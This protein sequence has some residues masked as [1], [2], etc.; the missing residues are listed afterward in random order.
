MILTLFTKPF[1]RAL[2]STVLLGIFTP[3]TA[4]EVSAISA[5][6]GPTPGDLFQGAVIDAGP[7]TPA[8]QSG[9][10]LRDAFGGRFSTTEPGR[11]VLADNLG[12]AVQKIYFHTAAPV[13]LSS[14]KLYLGDNGVDRGASHVEVA[15]TNA[16]FSSN[17]VFSTVDLASPY[18]SAVGENNI[19]HILISDSFAPVTGQYFVLHL[20][21][22]NPNVGVR[23]I[24]FDGV[25]PSGILA[26]T[27]VDFSTVGFTSALTAQTPINGFTYG[28]YTNSNMTT[29]TFSTDN[30]SVS[31]VEWR[32]TEASFTPIHRAIEMHP[33]GNTLRS[34]VRRYTVGSGG[35]PAFTGTVRIVGR[36][37]FRQS[38][39][40]SRFVTVDGTNRR[41]EN[42]T[43]GDTA[44]DFTA[45]VTPASTIDFG[46]AVGNGSDASFDMTGLIAWIVSEDAPVPTRL[47]ANAYNSPAND[48]DACFALATDLVIGATDETSFDTAPSAA[49]FPYAFAGLL[50]LEN[51]GSGKAT[52]FDSVRIDMT[53]S[54]DFSETPRLYLLRHNSDPNTSN[55]A[56]DDAT[57][58]CPS[59]RRGL[60]R[61]ARASLLTRSTSAR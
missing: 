24:E 5:D 11:A 32:S 36:F 59:C 27:H 6:P 46:V 16:T 18:P 49:A 14:F 43:T 53:T 1:F 34:A 40:T 52:R 47:L 28:Y 26:A 2:C 31:G 45:N 33:S 25:A 29:G 50:Y 13:T 57:R 55:P 41:E 35:E 48:R 10:D 61:I 38:G 21:P 8:H 37:F 15:V 9:H 12:S 23:V 17:T 3:A 60:R 20:T 42:N 7:S 56:A 4:A 44:F 58:A 39:V 22:A 19:R 54:G 30:M 51:V